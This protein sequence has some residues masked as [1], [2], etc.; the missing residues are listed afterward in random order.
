MKNYVL[1]ISNGTSFKIGKNR[2]DLQGALKRKD[3]MG[4]KGITVDVMTEN[5]AFGVK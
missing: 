4:A 5:E 1:V 3:E 2:Y